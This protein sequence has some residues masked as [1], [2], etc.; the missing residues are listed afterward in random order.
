[1]L[2]VYRRYENHTGYDRACIHT[3]ERWLCGDFCDVAR[4]CRVMPISKVKSH[5]LDRSSHHTGYLLRMRRHENH[6]G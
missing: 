4:L 6:T 3:Q 5:K 2:T 1:M